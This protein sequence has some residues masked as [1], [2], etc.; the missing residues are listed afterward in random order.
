MLLDRTAQIEKDSVP[1]RYSEVELPYPE[2]NEC[3][4][5]SHG[6]RRVPHGTG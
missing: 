1:L 4:D 6:L 5:Q 3:L 2:D